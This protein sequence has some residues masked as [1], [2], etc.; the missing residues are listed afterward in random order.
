[1]KNRNFV[2]NKR[3][4]IYKKWF[5]IAFNINWLAMSFIALSQ[6]NIASI[7]FLFNIQSSDLSQPSPL[8]AT[9][10]LFRAFLGGWMFFTT[11]LTPFSKSIFPGKN[12][13]RDFDTLLKVLVKMT[14]ISIWNIVLVDLGF[15][16]QKLEKRLNDFT[17]YFLLT[18]A[19]LWTIYMFLRWW[20]EKTKEKESLEQIPDFSLR[21]EESRKIRERLSEKEQREFATLAYENQSTI[22]VSVSNIIRIIVIY[23]LVSFLAEI[24]QEFIAKI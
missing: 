8:L 24:A 20:R 10:N 7:Q 9:I 15:R 12:V 18:V 16:I 4:E 2:T 21:A 23:L 5:S 19:I 17:L 3:N 13:K 11:F 1:M 14:Y 22:S 6:M